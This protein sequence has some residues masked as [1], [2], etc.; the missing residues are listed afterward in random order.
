MYLIYEI[1]P[2]EINRKLTAFILIIRDV[3]LTNKQNYWSA[4]IFKW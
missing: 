1:F 4:N 2:R 3:L